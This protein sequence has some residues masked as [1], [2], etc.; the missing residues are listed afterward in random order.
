MNPQSSNS[1]TLAQFLAWEDQQPLRHEFDGSLPE[2][3]A[4]VTV[5]HAIIQA[6]LAVA[7]GGRLRGQSCQFFGSILKILVGSSSVRY[8]DG[9]VT[10]AKADN[11]ATIIKDPVVIFEVLSP[12]SC[13]RDLTV[14]NREYEETASVQHYVLIMQDLIGAI[15]FSRESGAWRGRVLTDGDLLE[16][17]E[18]GI[19][20]PL[21]ELYTGLD[22]DDAGAEPSA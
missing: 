7:V 11:N 12:E 10:C 18:V 8:P 3:R 16:L 14:K 21:T 1:M 2:A 5:G 4:D 13:S 17:P 22:F 15:V 20:F 19:A 6:N 9:F